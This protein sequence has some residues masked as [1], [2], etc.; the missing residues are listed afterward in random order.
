MLGSTPNSIE[1]LLK[2]GKHM[3]YSWELEEGTDE[4]K[5]TYVEKK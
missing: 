5:T 1:I 3:I 2:N 4:F